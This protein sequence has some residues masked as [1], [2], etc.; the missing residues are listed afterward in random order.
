MCIIIYIYIRLLHV[1]KCIIY[2][3]CIETPGPLASRP[4]V[5][6]SSRQLRIRFFFGGWPWRAGEDGNLD[7]KN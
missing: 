3:M 6:A 7:R 1:H 5:S 4:P 2:R